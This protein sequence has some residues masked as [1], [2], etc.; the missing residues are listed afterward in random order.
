[1]A[2]YPPDPAAGA[3][4]AA[5][6]VLA[7]WRLEGAA[8]QAWGS[9]LINQTFRVDAG[10]AGRFALQRLNRIFDPAINEDIE[11]LTRHLQ[12]K[13]LSTPR[14]VPACDG[15]LWVRH[16]DAPWRLL[17]WIDGVTHDT[18]A[19]AAQARSA[20]AL[21]AR[22]HGAAADLNRALHNRR[23]GVH[24]LERHLRNL[25]L[26]LDAHRDHPRHAPVA[27]LARRVLEAARA[28]PA[29]PA[30]PDRLVHGDP[31][32]S[33]FV[34]DAAGLRANCLIDLDT[35]VY[36]PLPLELGDALRSWCN[37]AGED[38]RAA[39]FDLA[40]FEAAVGGYAGIGAAF[41]S[42]AEWR[43]FVP[44]TERIFVELAARFC[45][46]ALR[47]CYFGWDPSRYRSRGEHNEVRAAGQLAG[48]AALASVRARAQAIVADAFTD[49]GRGE[50]PRS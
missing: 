14:L 22:F 28:L 25:R 30:L 42:E 8:C 41:V 12:A 5:R 19:N 39:R 35:L 10:S 26:A 15:R 47:E 33:N 27:A 3:L 48:A 36:M 9:G 40:L 23:P 20:G 2:A 38:S 43:A 17:T 50:R 29:L 45:A 49:P 1:M 16:D 31:K 6:R 21:L 46:D 13:G 34:F 37:P 4:E 44:A 18:L 7:A 32:I 24:D 11:A